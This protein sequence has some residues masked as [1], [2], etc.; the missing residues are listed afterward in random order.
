MAYKINQMPPAA[1]LGRSARRERAPDADIGFGIVVSILLVATNTLVPSSTTVWRAVLG[2]L[3][4]LVLP[5]YYFVEMVFPR[6]RE[7]DPAARWVLALVMSCASVVVMSLLISLANQHWPG[8]V[9]NV[10]DTTDAICSAIVLF[11]AVAW[12][13]RRRLMPDEAS[14]FTFPRGTIP[15][16][17]LAFAV[18]L[19]GLAWGIAGRNLSEHAP[20]LA[21]TSPSGQL[22][23]YPFQIHRGEL[24]PLQVLITNPTDTTLRLRLIIADA[25]GTLARQS[26][27]IP[28]HISWS[29]RVTLPSETLGKH[30]V[31]SF[32]LVRHGSPIRRAWV[33][34]LVVP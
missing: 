34:Y 18:V 15:K 1:P 31:V 10:V 20:E 21:L 32:V 19:S 30:E 23:G 11:A 29:R 24:Y 9:L 3:A 17:V 6:R 22:S 16:A 14:G 4:T 26:L 2:L 33:R 25:R 13:R 28:A 7:I 12:W 27:S 5:G 8:I